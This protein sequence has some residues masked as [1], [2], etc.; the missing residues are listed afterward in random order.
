MDQHSSDL[1]LQVEALAAE[2][3]RLREQQPVTIRDTPRMNHRGRLINLS[4]SLHRSLYSPIKH[5]D[6]ND[7]SVVICLFLSAAFAS[8]NGF[9]HLASGG[10]QIPSSSF[11]C[12]TLHSNL[13]S[14]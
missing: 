5:R 14:Q 8:L 2:I 6:V 10:F 9:P 3:K 1:E 11:I 4:T 7:Y 13:S 12:S